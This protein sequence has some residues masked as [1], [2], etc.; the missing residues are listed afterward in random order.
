MNLL[1]RT[2]LNESERVQIFELWNNQYPIG[3]R[4]HSLEDFENYLEG[5][6][7]QSH[8]LVKDSLGSVI[9]WYFDFVREKER[10]FAIIIDSKMHRK[11]IG[12]NLLERAKQKEEELNGWVI[13]HDLDKKHNGENYISPL[14]FYL[15]NGFRL[16]SDS[17][18]KS[19]KISAVK[20]RWER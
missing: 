4:Y 11:G 8:L 19:D 6:T 12:Q 2:K 9:A 10:W 5:L 7:N 15:K 1:K 20:V 3:L 18:L 14:D 17:R 13:D 16:L